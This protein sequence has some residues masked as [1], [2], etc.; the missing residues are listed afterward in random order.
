LK[1]YKLI[2]E[3]KVEKQILELDNKVSKKVVEAIE[4][5]KIEPRPI[6]NVKLQVFDGYRIRVGNIRILYTISDINYVVTIYKVSKRSD[7][8]SRN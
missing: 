1:E 8:Y 7:A 2:I 4:K 5:L 6:G 3:K